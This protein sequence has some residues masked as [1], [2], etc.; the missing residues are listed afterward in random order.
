MDLKYW[1]EVK[2]AKE[3]GLEIKAW[4]GRPSFMCPYC[5]YD[6]LVLER[7]KKHIRGHS[8]PKVTKKT[9]H[10]VDSRGNKIAY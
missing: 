2:E 4:N 3:L 7:L 9:D 8:P 5:L 6:D 10:I 1:K